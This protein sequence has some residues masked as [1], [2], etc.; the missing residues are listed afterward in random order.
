MGLKFDSQKHNY[1][2]YINFICLHA[3]NHLLEQKTKLNSQVNPQN[4]FSPRF[5]PAWNSYNV[6]IRCFY[7]ASVNAAA[8]TSEGTCVLAFLSLFFLHFWSLLTSFSLCC[9]ICFIIW[10]AC[11][12]LLN[13]HSTA[14]PAASYADGETQWDA[15]RTCWVSSESPCRSDMEISNLRRQNCFFLNK[16]VKLEA[17]SSDSC[18]KSVHVHVVVLE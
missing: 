7:V 2:S 16:E 18:L 12:H 5:K 15:G 4:I 14:S 6:C 17:L 3:V 9:H 10:A 1:S 8:G 11:Y 13:S